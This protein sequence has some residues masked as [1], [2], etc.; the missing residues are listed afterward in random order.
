MQTTIKFRVPDEKTRINAIGSLYGTLISKEL[1]AIIPRFKPISPPE[2]GEWL[3]E[4]GEA[5][6]TYDEYLTRKNVVTKQRNVIYIQPLEES[7][8]EEFLNTMKAFVKAFYKGM[9]AK[10][11]PLLNVKNLKVSSREN[12]WSGKLQYNSG[13]IIRALIPKVPKD[14]HCMIGICLTD[15]YPRDSWNFGMN[16]LL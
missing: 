14:A 8:D 3:A 16:F 4:N 15:L 12:D 5:G 1:K 13:E 10:I 9:K 7:I 11:R 2:P 6:Q